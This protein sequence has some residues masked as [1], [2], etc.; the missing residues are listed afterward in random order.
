M[1][2]HWVATRPGGLDV[3]SFEDHDVPAPGAGEVTIE[4]RAAGMN[5]AD[6][7]HVARGG[8]EDFPRPI[9]YEVAGVVT[10]VGPDTEIASGP[11][12]TGDEVLAFRISGGWATAVTVPAGD[13]FAK[14][15]SLSFGEAANLLLAGST[16]AEMLHVTGVREGETVL[17]HGA[18]GAVGVSV[19]QQAAMLEATVV[20]T[21]SERSSGMVRRFGGTPVAYGDGLEQRV[22]DFAPDGVAAA[23]DCVGTDEAVDVSLAL[24]ADRE[25]VVTIAA[26]DRA[27]REGFRAIA[28]AMPASQAFRDAVRADLVRLAGEGRLV[29]PVARTFPLGDAVEAT[30]LLMSGHPGGKLVLEP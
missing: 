2:K 23:L 7:K 16:A 6:A 15:A 14:P 21:A 28:G 5:P 20:G 10:A 13:V 29:V 27:R 18:S 8:P 12:A 3:F 1:A 25:R 30:E 4:V 22:R 26:A 17:V 19:L 11:V 9:G 24:V